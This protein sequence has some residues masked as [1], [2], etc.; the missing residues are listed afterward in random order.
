M[1]FKKIS[2]LLKE[3]DLEKRRRYTSKEFQ[4]YGLML[5]SELDDWKN[6]SLYIKLAKDLPREWLD[7]ARYF[8]KD[9]PPKKIKSKARLFMWKLKQIKNEKK[10]SR[11][12]YSHQSD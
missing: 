2:S 12:S 1:D 9:Q 6:R 11:S 5:A 3:F 4:S 8:I 10:K 7:Q